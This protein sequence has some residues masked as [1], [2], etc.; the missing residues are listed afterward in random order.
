MSTSTRSLPTPLRST[1]G[2]KWAAALISAALGLAAWWLVTVVFPR[3]LFPGPIETV[4][5]SAELLASGI[6][7][8]HMEA[9][10]FRTFL[11]FIGA[12]FVGGALGVAMGIN[13]FGENFSTPII[14]IA[15]SV[16]GIA[17]AAITTIIFGFGVAA[18]VVATAVTVFPYISLRIWKGVEDI[19][20]NLIRMS[21][22]FDISKTRLLR[23]MILPSIAPALFTAVRFG[24]AIS[25]KIETQAEIFAS[26]SG[27]GYR[28]IEAFSRYQYDTA[29]AW[30]AVFV[31]IVFL[32]EMAVLRPLERKVF[33]YRK[34]ADFGVL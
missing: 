26:N 32:L 24:L 3:G 25:W 16:P 19:D 6:V 18:P 2:D 33:A 12:F 22:S 21:R 4:N 23:R 30:A 11:G 10:F 27:V 17:W 20:P 7:W 8:T 28:A 15:L 9:T 31:V 1:L 34:E 5:A 29:M 14:I 13:N